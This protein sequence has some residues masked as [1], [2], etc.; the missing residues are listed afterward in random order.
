[1]EEV[2]VAG[3]KVDDAT[4][5]ARQCSVGGRVAGVWGGS[6]VSTEKAEAGSLMQGSPRN[7]VPS[8][9]TGGAWTPPRVYDGTVG[10]VSPSSGGVARGNR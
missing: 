3:V 7:L 8:S 9:L 1:M 4:S 2:E 10:T 6:T 5:R